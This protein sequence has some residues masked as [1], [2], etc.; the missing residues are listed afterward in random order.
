MGFYSNEILYGNM[1]RKKEQAIFIH[2]ILLIYRKREKEEEKTI[3][4][5][6]N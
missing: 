5:L 4:I 3:F 2:R 1:S 6:S